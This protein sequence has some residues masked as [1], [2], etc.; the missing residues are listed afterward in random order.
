MF[1]GIFLISS[2]WYTLLSEQWMSLSLLV[3]LVTIGW[4]SLV[5]SGVFWYFAALF[6]ALMTSIGC[7]YLPTVSW[8]PDRLS[9][10]FRE[11][12]FYFACLVL[13]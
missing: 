1:S 13:V 9:S 2:R 3:L 8:M 6:V 10:T 12:G 11:I 4:Y 5:L 7:L